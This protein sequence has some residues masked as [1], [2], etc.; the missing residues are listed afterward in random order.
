MKILAINSSFRGNKG[1]TKFLIDKIFKG[2]KDEGAECES[3]NLAELHINHCIDCQSCQTEEHFLKCIHKDDADMVFNKMRQADIIIF[4]T[5]IYTLDMSSLLKTLFER[6]YYNCKIGEFNITNSGLFFHHVDTSLCSKPFV[7][8]ITCDNMLKETTHTTIEYF[9]IYAKFLDSKI[10]G[11]LVRKQGTVVGH[12]NKPE[13]EKAYPIIYDI[14]DAYYNAGKELAAKGFITK[15]TENRANRLI[16]K[17]PFYLKYLLRFAH[18]RK[19][20]AQRYEMIMD[21]AIHR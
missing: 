21:T 7:V 13:K 17:V 4:A 18:F 8:L 20:A 1:Y 19:K 9:K 5:P 3:I 12:G 15:S 10:A 16:F 14:Y 2:A 6:Y 11:I